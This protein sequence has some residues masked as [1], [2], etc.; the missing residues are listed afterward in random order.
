[1]VLASAKK[2]NKEIYGDFTILPQDALLRPTYST[3]LGG[4]V[5]HLD[6]SQQAAGV[7]ARP[8]DAVHSN[9]GAPFAAYAIT[10]LRFRGPAHYRLS[11]WLFHVPDSTVRCCFHSSCS[12]WWLDSGL[13]DTVGALIP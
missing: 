1:M 11:G 2:T 3:L 6:G 4:Q 5:Q 9:A 13:N 7:V 8:D 10:R 12:K